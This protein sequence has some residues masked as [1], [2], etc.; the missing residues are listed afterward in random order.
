[1]A[2][3]GTEIIYELASYFFALNSTVSGFEIF[4]VLLVFSIVILIILIT[5]FGLIELSGTRIINCELIVSAKTVEQQ[6][7]TS[8]D[9][10]FERNLTFPI[11][12]VC[13][14]SKIPLPIVSFTK[15]AV[16]ENSGSVILIFLTF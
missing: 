10:S 6:Y 16:P 4:Q 1:M 7:L 8:N 15:T 5:S 3:F 2:N 13:C 11:V 9:V 12:A 14:S